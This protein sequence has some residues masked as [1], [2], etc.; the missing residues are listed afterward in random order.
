MWCV[1]RVSRWA[2]RVSRWAAC[3]RH[4]RSSIPLSAPRAGFTVPTPLWSFLPAPL[5][6]PLVAT[7]GVSLSSLVLGGLMSLVLG[8]LPTI[9]STATIH[10]FCH[11]Q[12]RVDEVNACITKHNEWHSQQGLY[13]GHTVRYKAQPRFRH[14]GIGVIHSIRCTP[15]VNT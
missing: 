1:L 3:V 8:S 10:T 4:H 2:L 15:K 13:I 6:A 5:L 14:G 9:H 11:K 7:C 12:C